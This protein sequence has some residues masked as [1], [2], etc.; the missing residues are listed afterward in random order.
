MVLEGL[1]LKV[2][3]NLLPEL[4]LQAVAIEPEEALQAIP[5]ALAGILQGQRLEFI[6]HFPSVCKEKEVA[7]ALGE[8]EGTDLL[9]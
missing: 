1:L 6:V 5:V 3:E 7:T 8:G 9:K 4:L 2:V